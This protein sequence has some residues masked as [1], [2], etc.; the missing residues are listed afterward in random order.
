MLRLILSDK[1]I[2]TSQLFSGQFSDLNIDMNIDM[3]RVQTINKSFVN[4]IVNK[5]GDTDIK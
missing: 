4:N 1:L 5:T 3:S 2:A